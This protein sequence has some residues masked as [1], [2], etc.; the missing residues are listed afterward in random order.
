MMT[1][2][3]SATRSAAGTTCPKLF[4]KLF[5]GSEAVLEEDTAQYR[6]L[7]TEH[8]P[9]AGRLLASELLIPI[10]TTASR[11]TMGPDDPCHGH[12]RRLQQHLWPPRDQRP[13]RRPVQPGRDRVIEPGTS[14]ASMS[15]TCITAAASCGCTREDSVPS[16]QQPVQLG[17]AI[18]DT[19]YDRGRSRGPGRGE[20]DILEGETGSTRSNHRQPSTQLTKP[21]L[22]TTASASRRWAST[23]QGAVLDY[24]KIAG[25]SGSPGS[26]E[27]G[28][29]GP[30]GHRLPL[31]R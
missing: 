17:E 20:I 11:W 28:N 22:S 18:N 4:D 25:R 2:S 31:L 16:I 9:A 10:R 3:S 23:L 6:D 26:G 19:S 5:E 24:P 27:T 15:S 7:L 12:R 1:G 8:T 30:R 29:G 14:A 13:H 21:R